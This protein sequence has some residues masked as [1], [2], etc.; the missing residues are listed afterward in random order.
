MI[1][2]LEG[3]HWSNSHHTM[4]ED[5]SHVNQIYLVVPN[6]LHPTAVGGLKCGVIA[7]SRT[8]SCSDL[9]GFTRVANFP[10]PVNDF[11]Q[12]NFARCLIHLSVRISSCVMLW[13]GLP[14]GR[15]AS[16]SICGF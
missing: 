12:Q 15:V 10:L 14:Q 11:V 16:A 2:Y 4:L 9:D 8:T 3:L 13:L 5:I 1:V 7:S 6:V